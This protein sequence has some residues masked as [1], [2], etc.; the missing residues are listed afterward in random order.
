MAWQSS[1]TSSDAGASKQALAPNSAEDA[2]SFWEVPWVRVAL[3]MLPVAL[4]YNANNFLVFAVLARVNLDA[5][6]V[7]RNISIIFNALLWVWT[8]QRNLSLHRWVAL[9]ICLLACCLNSL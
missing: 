2:G 7:W 3:R 6:A 8:M 4:I 5:Y 1:S 9:G